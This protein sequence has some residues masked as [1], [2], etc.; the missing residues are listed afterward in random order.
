[1]NYKYSILT[2]NYGNYEVLKD[3]L[4]VRDDVEYICVTDDPNLQSN[5][6]TIVYKPGVTFFYA[7]HHPFEFVHTDTCLWIDAS[8]LITGDLTDQFVDPFIHSDKELAISLH[9]TRHN[10]YEESIYWIF[11]RGASAAN[12]SAFLREMVIKG[13]NTDSLFQTSVIL[14]KNTEMTKAIYDTVNEMDALCS[15]EGFYRDDQ[16]LFTYAICTTAYRDSRILLLDFSATSN[17]SCLKWFTHGADGKQIIAYQKSTRC[18]DEDQP[19]L[20]RIK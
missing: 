17:N 10:V 12:I 13:F 7:K 19:F 4:V 9:D 20:Y 6:W 5:I 16:S 3:P 8:Y 11:Q 18:F 2:C 15:I 14:S 1:M